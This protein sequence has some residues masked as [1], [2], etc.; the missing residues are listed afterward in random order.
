[1]DHMSRVKE[2]N[3]AKNI[4]NDDQNMLFVEVVF[5]FIFQIFVCILSEAF[6]NQEYIIEKLI[7]IA[8]SNFLTFIDGWNDYIQ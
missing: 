4:I 8:L 2:V 6:L 1:M 7:G 3:S 5:A